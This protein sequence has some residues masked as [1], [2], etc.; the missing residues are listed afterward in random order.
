MSPTPATDGSAP[1]S[2]AY[3]GS[4]GGGSARIRVT[5]YNVH[6][7]DEHP[8][9]S[10]DE[11]ATLAREPQVVTWIDV[12]GVHDAETVRVVCDRFGIHP[13]TVEDILDVGTRI[14]YEPFREYVFV[15]AAMLDLAERPDDGITPYTVVVESLNLVV[16]EGFVLTFQ[17][18]ADDVFDAVRRRIREGIGYIRGFGADYLAY[19]LLDAVVDQLFVVQARI[20]GTVEALE[21]ELLL[22]ARVEHV[23]AIHK[24]RR[25][26]LSVRKAASPLR[27]VVA[28]LQRA[29]PTLMHEAVK[30]FLRD[31][32]DHV[33][34]VTE[35][36][37]LFRDV[38][39][40]LSDLY[41]SRAD[42]RLNETMMTL[43][44]IGTIFMPL[45]FITGLYGMNF[46]YMPEL[47]LRWGYAAVWALM[48][49]VAGALTLFFRR[50][51]W[52]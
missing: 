15:S 14:K 24:V 42:A 11:A 3:T 7:V 33:A 9:V 29:E 36:A 52:L 4:A 6:R 31:L 44:I 50:K 8:D 51:R 20:E 43:T 22:D 49:T 30:P 45:T 25:Q 39:S 2:G 16:G 18:D 1:G 26:L 35:A 27:E 28:G 19:V 37:E 32:R 23:M 41:Q 21:D 34:Q 46:H 38:A 47:D 10:L 17:E 48:L 5:T 40:G 12:V 13:L